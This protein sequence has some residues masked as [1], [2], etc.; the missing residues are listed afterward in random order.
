MPHLRRGD[1]LPRIVTPPPGPRSR[2]L[3]RELEAHEA[4]GINT[5]GRGPEGPSPRPAWAEARGSNVLD[6]DGNRYLDLTAGFGVAA[7]GHRHPRV[8]AA[9]RRQSG[10]L[11]HGLG[12]VHPHPSRVAVADRLARLAPVD[13]PRVYFGISGAEA[14]EIALKTALLATG[15]PGVVAFEPAYHGLTLGALAATSRPAFRE[16]FAVWRGVPVHRLPYG[17]DPADLERLLAASERGS[18]RQGIGALL[19]EPVVGREGGIFPPPGW[20]AEITRRARRHGVPVIS[21]EIFVGFGRTGRWFGVDADGVRPD[22]LVCGKALGGGL[23]LAAVVGR[24]ELM[25]RWSTPGEALHT[26]TFVAHP[27]ACAAALACLDVLEE[28]DLPARAAALGAVVADRLAP[29]CDRVPGIREVRGR[30]LLW[31]LELADA[32]LAGT[33][34]AGLRARGVLALAGGPEGRVLQLTPPLT[35][36]DRQLAIAMDLVEETLEDVATRR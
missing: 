35:I 25:A 8:V 33:A 16:P 3:A 18:D 14:V 24:R 21:D 20:L 2:D 19:F 10:R 17:G 9:V 32:T 5:V 15:R 23:P 27:L 34:V 7:V 12:D 30:G 22:L 1:L 36:T 28:E 26:A 13:E 6:V 11:I 4:P 29:L 31:A